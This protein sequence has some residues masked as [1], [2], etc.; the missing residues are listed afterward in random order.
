MADFAHFTPSPSQG[1]TGATLPAAS[2]K[3][4]SNTAIAHPHVCMR[5]K[6]SRNQKRRFW[7]G[8][9]LSEGSTVWLR[10]NIVSTQ[11]READL[12]VAHEHDPLEHVEELAGRLVDRGDQ[13]SVVSDDE[14]LQGLHQLVCQSRVQAR[15]WLLEMKDWGEL[16][17]SLEEQAQMHTQRHKQTDRHRRVQAQTDT[18]AN[19]LRDTQTHRH[20]Q[21]HIHTDTHRQI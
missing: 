10:D 3:R 4:K 19:T 2:R 8:G 18:D 1:R 11:V 15:G 12:A 20:I 7:L 14:A 21:K 17:T 9:G 16:L 6:L 13:G 5:E